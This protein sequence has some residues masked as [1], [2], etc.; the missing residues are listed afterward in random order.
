MEAFN[1]SI[2]F[3]KR[4]YKVDVQGSQA[5]AKAL[6]LKGLVTEAEMNA[7]IQGLDQVAQ[8]WENNTFQINSSDEDIHTANERRL[9][10]IIG[11]TSGKLHTGRS[12]NDQIATDMRL[13]LRGETQTLLSHLLELI[14]VTVNRSEKEIDVLMPGYTHLQHAQ[15][16]RWSHW[17]LSYA[18]SW[19][20]DAEKLHLLIER[21]NQLPLGSGALAGNPFQIDRE[22]LA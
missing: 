13:W 12:R 10:E 4:L 22:F 3:D 6:A 11:P 7:L 1:A 15:P 2:H 20:A 14:Q 9:N 18:W 8:E 21:I 16:I 19:F 5:Y 17:L